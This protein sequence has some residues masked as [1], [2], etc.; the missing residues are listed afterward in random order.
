M[1]PID[2]SPTIGSDPTMPGASS[3][4]TMGLIAWLTES[5]RSET[6]GVLAVA[7]ISKTAALGG[8][9]IGVVSDS[10]LYEPNASMAPPPV[11]APIVYLISVIRKPKPDSPVGP[12]L[13]VKV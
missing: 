11:P 8:M 3:V 5:G 2:G 10:D 1:L 13:L 12:G 6:G 7:S 9:M 4:M